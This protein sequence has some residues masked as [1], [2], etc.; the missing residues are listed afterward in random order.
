MLLF[1]FAR[2]PIRTHTHI[3]DANLCVK[4]SQRQEKAKRGAPARHELE[5]EMSELSVCWWSGLLEGFQLRGGGLSSS[6]DSR[7]A[8]NVKG[9]KL[10][11]SEV[12]CFP[13]L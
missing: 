4:K 3:H 12:G 1:P 2:A 5:T 10:V 8:V 13:P 7:D 6:S 11:F 9:G